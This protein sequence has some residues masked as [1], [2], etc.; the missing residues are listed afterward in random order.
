MRKIIFFSCLLLYTISF[1]QTFTVSDIE[2]RVNF[3]AT[4]PPSVTAIDYL[5]SGGMVTIPD[6]VFLVSNSTTYNVTSIR[7]EAFRGDLN[8]ELTNITIGN[9]VSSIGVF[10]FADNQITDVVIP[11]SVI[12]IEDSAFQDNQIMNLTLGN[13]VNSIGVF[14]FTRNKLTSISIP[15]SVISIE[16]NAFQDNL[17]TSVDLGNGIVSI[18]DGAFVGGRS[19][20]NNQLTEITIPDSV[21][22]IGA[23]AFFENKLTNVTIGNKVSSIGNDAFRDN[24]LG[25]V[26][27]PNSVVSIG[28]RTFQ[29]NQL[30]DVLIPNNV[31][32]IG[33]EAFENNNLTR[34]KLGDGLTS[35][36]DNTFFRNN[37][38][39]DV[40]SS[41]PNPVI[42]PSGFNDPFLNSSNNS[43]RA[44]IDLTVPTGAVQAYIDAGWTGF[45]SITE[46]EFTIDDFTYRITSKSPNGVEVK[47]YLGIEREITIPNS[48]INNGVTFNVTSIRFLALTLKQ[49][50]SVI[51]PNNLIT[52]GAAAFRNNQ[53]T[54]VTIPNNVTTILGN[55][56]TDNLLTNVT[57]P[58]NVQIIFEDAF[59]NNNLLS[60]TIGSGV[61]QLGQGTFSGNNNLTRVTSLSNSPAM[62][63]S[64][65]F[66]PFQDVLGVSTRANIDLIIPA[67]TLQAYTDAGWTGFKSIN[68]EVT[69][70][71]IVYRVTSTNP[72]RVEVR[73]YLITGGAVT[74]PDTVMN[75]GVTFSVTSV[76][77]NAFNFNQITS[78]SI[79]N[80]VIFIDAGAFR[81][82]QL[83]SINIPDNVTTILGNAFTG[84]QL[85]NVIIPNN[86]T[87]IFQDAFA[88]NNITSV[89]SLNTSPP[90]LFGD[91]FRDELD[92]SIRANIDLI[93]PAGT[94]QAYIDA[95][96]TGFKSV[97]ED[98]SL[99]IEGFE[100]DN[101]IGVSYRENKIIIIS[102]NNLELQN[103]TI[104]NISGALI[105]SGTENEIPTTF[106]ASAI[107][108]LEL[109]FDRGT[110]TKK[111]RIHN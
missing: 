11:D 75:N 59:K 64:G 51:L 18:G 53:L 79:P 52:I 65:D 61:T 36:G 27:I 66:D 44:N 30:T 94:L 3:P 26:F 97:T 28:D 31:T 104:Y 81:E 46:S 1:S 82:N 86:V 47:S 72:N 85:T 87:S 106:L 4:M 108:I 69:I 84:N 105:T 56:F 110:L 80:N 73:D 83:V 99:S 7:G 45:K 96:W 68:E 33:R 34:V 91:P 39:T 71:N 100:I 43:I 54:S 15:D 9:N 101:E 40:N 109:N 49:L 102:S 6:M 55:A 2:Y 93:I 63:S 24:Q 48:V 23:E 25:D 111:I 42:L 60:V 5:G 14:A 70:D 32:S 57:I 89:T 50:E 92:V 20:D 107:Y 16:A 90:T 19:I 22:S 10:A 17:L 78:V 38:I 8:N 95:G 67:G 103:Y 37:D 76:G 21:I 13:S 12:P 41:N 29:G 88:E 77:L 62:I 35:I 98:G 58:N 74:I